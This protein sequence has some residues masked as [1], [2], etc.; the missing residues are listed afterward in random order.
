[1][2]ISTRWIDG[3]KLLEINVESFCT[4]S[5]E[6]ITS[7]QEAEWLISNLQSV[8]DDLKEYAEEQGK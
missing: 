2:E 7:K 6:L 5:D 1:M 3:K 4:S 8:I